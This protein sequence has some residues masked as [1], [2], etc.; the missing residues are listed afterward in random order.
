LIPEEQEK[1][2]IEKYVLS[3]SMTWLI[4]N[5]TLQL[6]KKKTLEIKDLNN[7]KGKLGEIYV[8]DCLFN[9]LIKHG[10][11]HSKIAKHDSFYIRKYYRAKGRSGNGIDLYL[12]IYDKEGRKYRLLI[13][14]SNWGKYHTINEHIW[15]DRIQ[16]K[17]DRYDRLD[18]CIHIVA[19]NHRNVRLV[20]NKAKRDGTI[21][22]SLREHITPDFLSRIEEM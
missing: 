16:S 19:I 20:E 13:E 1:R 12:V 4:S 14:V 5:K 22:L 18:R 7:L 15:N 10:F 6:L 9:Q 21:I 17:F 8:Y 11:K 3:D 2:F